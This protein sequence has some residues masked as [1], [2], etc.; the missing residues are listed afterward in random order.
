MTSWA[1]KSHDCHPLGGLLGDLFLT[2]SELAGRLKIKPDSAKRLA[3]RRKWV[4]VIGND[5][6]AR[7]RVP[8]EAVPSDVGGDIPPDSVPPLPLDLSARVAYLE[9]MVEG[10][11]VAVNAERKRAEA[12]EARIRDL[13]E[14]RSAW[15]QQA[16][17]GIWSRIF[18]K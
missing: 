7:V 18:G 14:D 17:R 9:G 11:N 3:Q 6:L 4:R 15:R 1:S 16:L 12:A 8:L 2:Y 13:E 5:G 10:L